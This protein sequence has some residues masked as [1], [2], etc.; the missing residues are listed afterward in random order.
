ME[1]LLRE[2]MNA[3]TN[4][5]LAPYARRRGDGAAHH[6][7]GPTEAEARDLIAPVEEE[8]RDLLGDDLRRGRKE[9]EVAFALMEAQGLTCGVLQGPMARRMTDL[10]GASAVLKG[11]V[12]ICA[13]EVKHNGGVPQALLDQYGAVSPNCLRP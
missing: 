1:A 2:R 10:Q 4:P 5:T 8:L 7:Q 12:V 11:G 13:D 6:R 9:S 3:M